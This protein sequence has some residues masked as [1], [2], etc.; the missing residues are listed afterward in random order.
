MTIAV[1]ERLPAA[2]FKTMTEDGP[3]KLTTADIF[4]GKKVVLYFYP[5]ASTP[6]RLTSTTPLQALY[7]LN[8]EQVHEQSA[9]FARRLMAMADD[10]DA[11]ILQA[12]RLTLGRPPDDAERALAKEFL[13]GFRKQTRQA[14]PSEADAWQSLGR[15]LFRLNEFVYVD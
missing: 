5:A 8:D 9:G 7:F 11:R 2:T 6:E 1:G 3:E 15:A 13:A 10:E 14:G 12:Y 4:A